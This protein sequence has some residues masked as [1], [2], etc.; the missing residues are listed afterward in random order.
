MRHIWSTA[1]SAPRLRMDGCAHS[2][3]RRR[4]PICTTWPPNLSPPIGINHLVNG[5]LAVLRNGG[6]AALM[7]GH[8]TVDGYVGVLPVLYPVL[9]GRF[10]LDLA[11]VG[12]LSLAYTGLASVSQPLFGLV[13]DRWGTRFVGGALLW[14]GAWFAA[15]GF[16]PSFPLLLVAAGV[17]G[18]GS[19]C[20]HPLGALMVRALLPLR[21]ANSAMSVYVSGGTFGV[22]AGP[23]LGVAALVLFGVRGTAAL[24]VPG[25]AAAV[26]LLIYLRKRE[27]RHA[28]R[29]RDARRPLPVPLIPLGAT[30]LLMMSRSWVEVVLQSF[31]PTWYHQLGYGPWFYGPLATV[32]ILGSAMGTIGCGSLADRYGRRAVVLWALVLSVPAVALFAAFPG[33]QAFVTAA[34]VGFLAASTAPLMLMMAQELIAAR[35]GFASGLVMGIGFLAGAV[36]APVT[37]AIADHIG[38]QLALMLQVVVV[39]ITI[40]I[41]LLL[42]SEDFLRR[43]RDAGMASAPVPVGGE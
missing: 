4:R 14:T 9:I 24:F 32:V 26:F 8:F 40:P 39:V 2:G 41:A 15:L 19:G 37:G 22:A 36:G 1:A 3:A 42:P 18:L 6:I 30:I 29:V 20:F 34:V 28:T 33:P 23:L 38:L 35:A 16:M 7:L 13:A 21:H 31:I 27:G 17:A 12:L 11:T 25:V 5:V 10:H 43:H